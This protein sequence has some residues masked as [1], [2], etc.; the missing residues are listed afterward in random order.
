MEKINSVSLNERRLN[1]VHR[2]YDLPPDTSLNILA[3]GA[4]AVYQAP[5]G[6]ITL[7]GGQTQYFQAKA[8]TELTSTPIE[9]SFCQYAL[10]SKDVLVVPDTAQDSR[11]SHNPLVTNEPYV[12][13]YSGVAPCINE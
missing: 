3:R 9:E 2:F 7:L 12:R 8:G 6:L 13:F 5:I 4:A 11:F 10:D 1:W